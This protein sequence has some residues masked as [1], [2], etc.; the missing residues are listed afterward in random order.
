MRGLQCRRD[1]ERRDALYLPFSC[2]CL[3]PPYMVFLEQMDNVLTHCT[4]RLHV[5]VVSFRYYG[6]PRGVF[7]SCLFEGDNKCIPN[8]LIFRANVMFEVMYPDPS[9]S[10]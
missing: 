10:G 9:G 3:F 4:C 5:H 7:L 8:F 6:V 1:A 2:A